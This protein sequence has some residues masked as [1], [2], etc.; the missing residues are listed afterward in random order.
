MALCSYSFTCGER[1]RYQQGPHPTTEPEAELAAV[2]AEHKAHPFIGA[3]WS[4]TSL[5]ASVPG[6]QIAYNSGLLWLIYGLLF[7][8]SGLLFLA[9]WRSR[10]VL[11]CG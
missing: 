11:G 10:F 2:K 3:R 4:P 5:A 6:N 7:G 9:T 1:E 8:Y